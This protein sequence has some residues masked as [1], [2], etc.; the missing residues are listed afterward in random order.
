M[1]TKRTRMYFDADDD[2]KLAV[3]M[4]ALRRDTSASE[5]IGQILRDNL[6][7]ALAEARK[8]IQERKKGSKSE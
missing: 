1:S 5:L 8:V 4:E 7:H 3:Q 6:K 2:L